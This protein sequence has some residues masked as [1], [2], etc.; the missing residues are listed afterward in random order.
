MTADRALKPD[1]RSQSK[2]GEGNLFGI[3]RPCR[4]RLSESLATSR[5]AH[6]RGLR[7][8]LRDGH[9]QSARVAANYDGL[10]DS[11]LVEAPSAP[12][13]DRGHR[14]GLPPCRG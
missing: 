8:A 5:I 2:F 1:V 10:I 13:D 3:I 7:P 12:P 9:G 4:P 14:G 11:P 6:L